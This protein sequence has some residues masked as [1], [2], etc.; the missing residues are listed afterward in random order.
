MP[1]SPAQYSPYYFDASSGK[2][3]ER[4][5]LP[6]QPLLEFLLGP[7]QSRSFLLSRSCRVPRGASLPEGV[8]GK[9]ATRLPELGLSRLYSVPLEG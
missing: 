8:E 4:D 7:F 3:M 5:G 2:D 6:L 1:A 9:G